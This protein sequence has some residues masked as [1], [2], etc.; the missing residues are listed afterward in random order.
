MGRLKPGMSRQKALADLALIHRETLEDDHAVNRSEAEE[1]FLSSLRL[2]VVPT[3][4][5]LTFDLRQQFSQ[6]LPILMAM[7]GLVLL[8]AC[9]NVANLS[10]AR[11]ATRQKEIA[12][13]LA[14]GAG[15]RRLIRLLLTESLILASAGGPAGYLP[16]YWSGTMLASLVSMAW[17]LGWG[18]PRLDLQPDPRVLMFVV[19]SAGLRP[20]SWPE[21]R[22]PAASAMGSPKVAPAAINNIDSRTTALGRGAE[23]ANGGYRLVGRCP[24]HSR[25]EVRQVSSGASASLHLQGPGRLRETPGPLG[26]RTSPSTLFCESER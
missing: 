4:S 9:I 18:S 26:C 1:R 24:H 25:H 19:E 16:A 2:A 22:R 17:G 20:K 6:P 21:I 12:V 5:G 14:I 3:E 11:A 7:V 10:L 15:R 8:I 23:A 13:R